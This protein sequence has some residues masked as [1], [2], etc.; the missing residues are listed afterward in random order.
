MHVDWKYKSS[1]EP[2]RFAALDCVVEFHRA[3]TKA[4]EALGPIG[5]LAERQW[6]YPEP[7]PIVQVALKT[8]A[9]AALERLRTFRTW[10]GN[11][12]AEGAP[13][14][15][16]DAVDA[17]SN[18]IGFL[19][20]FPITPTAMLDADGCPMLLLTYAG[21]SGEITV[22]ADGTVEFVLDV[23]GSE[24]ESEVEV[25]FDNDAL[26]PSLADVMKRALSVSD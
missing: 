12:D 19:R 13:A 1:T 16:V 18:L 22:K 25:P 14:P 3:L 4:A 6:R 21:G 9:V 24:V 23:P 7:V 20:S 17:A 8:A 26:P 15:S 11:W 10:E 2:E 5:M